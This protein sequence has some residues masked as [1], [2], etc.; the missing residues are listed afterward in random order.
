MTASRRSARWQGI[1]AAAVTF[2]VTVLPEIPDRQ[3][4]LAHRLPNLPV[5]LLAFRID[6][7][8]T[9]AQCLTKQQ[10]VE[11]AQ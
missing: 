5:K 2:L 10:V 8:Q 3:R 9:Q 4:A 7:R 1:L 11:T 6:G